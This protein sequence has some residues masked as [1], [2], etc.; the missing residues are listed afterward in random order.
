MHPFDHW[1]V[2]LT[3]LPAL[4]ETVLH[5]RLAGLHND[6]ALIQRALDHAVR[7]W[8]RERDRRDN[9]TRCPRCHQREP[10]KHQRPMA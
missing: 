2:A 8:E 7:S 6:A 5:L 4:R 3:V 1:K 10:H 9:A